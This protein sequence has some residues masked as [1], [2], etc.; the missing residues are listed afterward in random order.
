MQ[1]CKYVIFE[2]LSYAK[3]GKHHYAGFMSGVAR[4]TNTD[5]VTIAAGYFAQ[6]KQLH[7]SLLE[8]AKHV[9]KMYDCIALLVAWVGEVEHVC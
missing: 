5:D 3:D 9:N 4:V 6:R 7:K 2:E 8:A 1:A